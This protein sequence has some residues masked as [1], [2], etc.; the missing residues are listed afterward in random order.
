MNEEKLCGL[1]YD[2]LHVLR[3]NKAIDKKQ[4]NELFKQFKETELD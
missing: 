2:L 3:D 1:L 4:F